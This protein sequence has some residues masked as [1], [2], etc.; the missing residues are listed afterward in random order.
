MNSLPAGLDICP[1]PASIRVTELRTGT[2]ATLC[3]AQV[4]EETR[5]LLRS[6]GLTDSCR[7]RLCKRGEPCILQVRT[8]RIGVSQ[9]VAE[10]L[11]VL[12]DKA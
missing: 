3:D 9:L 7:L 5:S 12:A 6:L 2:L 8:T 1:Q 4:D 10:R 11:F